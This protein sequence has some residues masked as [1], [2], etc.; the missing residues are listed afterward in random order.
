MGK[1][2]L[3]L[4]DRIVANSKV[5][6]NGCWEWHLP[7]QR[8]GRIRVAGRT[9]R[10]HRASWEAFRGAI[11]PGMNVLHH[12]D[13]PP[14]VNPDH[15]WLGTQMDN[16]QDCIA[17]GRSTPIPLC[18]PEKK[19][20]GDAN[21]MRK[22]PESLAGERN[23]RAKVSDGVR[24]NIATLKLDWGYSTAYLADVYEL[25][26]TSISRIVRKYRRKEAGTP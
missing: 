26:P 20:R 2:S 9:L 7:K 19:A 17:K 5:M 1:R 22:H 6:P 4:K 12:C 10:A 24:R 18:P 3:S 21:G 15:L 23:G 11:P 13:N 14:C 16:V 25:H 8:Y